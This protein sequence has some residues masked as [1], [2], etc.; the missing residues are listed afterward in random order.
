QAT[1]RPRKY[2][3]N[4]SIPTVQQSASRATMRTR[5]L[6]LDP[7]ISLLARYVR[8]KIRQMKPSSGNRHGEGVLSIQAEEPHARFSICDN[9]RSH[10]QFRKRREPRQRRRT[11]Q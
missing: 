6:I 10:I 2:F 4:R 5:A 9:V 3:A 7:S 8:A 1:L 11:A